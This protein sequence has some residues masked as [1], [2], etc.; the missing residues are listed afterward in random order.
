MTVNG[1]QKPSVGHFQSCNISYPSR[2]LEFLDSPSLKPDT[3]GH[4]TA[5][6]R[7]LD[8]L[9]VGAGL[10]GLAAAV[11]LGRHGHK[12]RVLEQALELGEVGAGIQ[13]PSNSARLLSR[14][15]VDRFWEGKAVEPGSITFRRWQCGRPVAHTQLKPGFA[16]K[17]GAPYLTIHRA[18]FHEALRQRAVELGVE[19]Q[20]GTRVAHF[21]SETPSVTTREGKTIRADLVLVASG[22]RSTAHESLGH[23][24]TNGAYRTGFA[25]YRA[26]VDVDKI[27]ADKELA[28][29]TEN[30]NLN[31][32]IGEDKHVMTYA[33]SAGSSFNMVLSHVD[34]SDPETWTPE[35]VL[36]DMRQQFADWDPQ[37]VRIVNMVDKTM[38]WPLTSMRATKHWVSVSGR[39]VMIGDAVHAMVPYMSQGAAMAVEDAA[40]L[41]VAVQHATATASTLPSST[42]KDALKVFER[43]R[44]LRACQMQ[45]ASLVNGKLWHLPDGPTQQARDAATRAEVEGE[46]FEVSANQW[47]DPVTQEWTY[48]YDAEAEMSRALR[49]QS[50]WDAQPGTQQCTA[51]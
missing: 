21:D 14:W 20:T 17:Y 18:H 22:V 1:K 46:P 35:G 31:V 50:L 48:G 51:G 45:Q 37:L 39:L 4:S 36:E 25:A 9:V 11:A 3:N 2:S 10:S 44:S 43:I 28:W 42:L 24:T 41:A 33:I 6:A 7:R 40:A 34:W 19:I 49:E 15:G 29:V 16:D 38:K 13:I 12:V 23:G 32:W 5:E 8:I 27:R 47:S 26:T 30:P